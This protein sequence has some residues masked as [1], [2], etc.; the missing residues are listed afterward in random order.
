MAGGQGAQVGSAHISIFP[1]MTGFRSAVNKEVRSAGA[2]AS[3]SFSSAFK[4]AGSK[5]GRQLG[6]EMKRAFSQASGDSI[7]DQALSVFRKDVAKATND[8]AKARRK[9]ADDAGRVQ[10]AEARLSETIA[11]SG[12]GSAAAV[13]ASERLRSARSKLQVSTASYKGAVDQLKSANEGLARAEAEVEKATSRQN[14]VLSRMASSV[15]S[16]VSGAF[17]S[18]RSAIT[19]FGKTAFSA[20]PQQVQSGLSKAF[21]GVSGVASRAFGG[22]KGAA[23][24][25]RSGVGAAFSAM[26]SGIKASMG[27]VTAIVGA[28]AAA[29]GAAVAAIGAPALKAYAD[30]EQLVGGVDTLFKDASG[31]VQ[32]YAANAYKTAGMSANTYMETV[33][34]FSA[35]LLQGLGGDTARAAEV[36]N[37]AITDMADNS[38]KMGTSIDSI[39]EAYQGFAKDNYDMLDNLKLGYGGTQAE[40]A[41]LINDSGVLGDSMKV[42][43]ENVRDV[44][45]DKMIEAIHQV[46]TEMGITGTTS[47][48][49]STTI[50][51][52]VASAKA[53]W[54][55]WLV[56]LGQ[57]NEQARASTVQ[58]VNAVSTAASNVVPRIVTIVTTLG[59]TI[60]DN[61]STWLSTELPSLLAQ[62]NSWVASSLPTI[63]ARG[64]DMLESVV[65]GIVNNLPQIT[66]SAVR[67]L[68][69]LCNGLSREMPKLIPLAMQMVINVVQGIANNLPQIVQSGVRLIASLVSGLSN[70][71]PQLIA[72]APV[73]IARLAAAVIQNLPTILGAGAQIMSSLASG[74]INAVGT[75]VGS[76]PGIIGQVKS[77]FT[78]INWGSVGRNIID[79]I[80]N[81]LTGAARGLARA[82]MNAANDALA[83]VKGVLGIA[84]PSRVF[85]DE[86]GK[87]IPAGIAVGIERGEG[88]MLSKADRLTRNLT[89][90]IEAGI[91]SIKGD[92][93]VSGDAASKRGP[94]SVTQIFNQQVQSPDEFA[95]TMRMQARYGIA[96][97]S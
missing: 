42:T 33:T 32:Q 70:A 19:N 61:A 21:S 1:T 88:S 36:A 5:S 28:G 48:E 49:A 22:V 23:E 2:S 26:S 94:V 50:S 87:M 86:V 62:F 27:A 52:S 68:T 39:R 95:R 25:M 60:A 89:E 8:L 4:G 77:A 51:G 80:K 84:S 24:S 59:N 85:R 75:L 91:P 20:L 7:A 79:G 58:L 44:P 15:R 66:D 18:A 97:A 81:G 46:Q 34:S 92:V 31:Q 12:E 67:L 78:N 64:A 83:W 41:R 55:N 96:A 54:D 6:L 9:M 29:M 53:A 38:N 14:G 45:F 35:S 30:Y 11:K 69:T 40:M 37:L 65:S 10:V 3:T 73:I 57:G 90:R 47:L 56:S 43:A 76:I 16:S 17:A 13:A 82:A 74:F 71:L 93:T 63:L 72:Q